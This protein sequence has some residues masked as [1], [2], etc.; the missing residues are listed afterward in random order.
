MFHLEQR[1]EPFPLKDYSVAQRVALFDLALE[2]EAGQM[3]EVPGSWISAHKE[4]LF[5]TAEE[6]ITENTDCWD[7]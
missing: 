1:I 4:V 5:A 7:G 2:A 3:N 6:G